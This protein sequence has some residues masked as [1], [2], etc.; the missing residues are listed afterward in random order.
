MKLGLKIATAAA[1]LAT[2]GAAGVTF[3]D[4]PPSWAV[5]SYRGNSPV[6][7]FR[8]ELHISSGGLVHLVMFKNH[9]ETGRDGTWV[10]NHIQFGHQKYLVYQTS[11]G[12]RIMK[13]SN[14]SDKTIFQRQ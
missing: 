11:D 4:A 13:A 3:A 2:I 8:E 12:M 5:G 1:A 6:N 14:H 10:G 9:G 7:N